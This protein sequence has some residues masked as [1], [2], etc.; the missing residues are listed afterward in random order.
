MG[1]PLTLTRTLTL[2]GCFEDEIVGV[3]VPVRG[4]EDL[5]IENDEEPFNLK[6]DKVTN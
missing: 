2:I 3:P 1:V 4:K 5:F 6:A